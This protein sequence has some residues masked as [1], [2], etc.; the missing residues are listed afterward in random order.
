MTESS[1]DRLDRIE[2]TLERVSQQMDNQVVLNAEL[3]QK[4]A[5]LTDAVNVLMTSVTFL[6]GV[7]TNLTNTVAQHQEQIQALTLETRDI[8]SDMMEMQREMQA[9]TRAIR[10]DMREMQ[11]ENRRILDIIERRFDGSN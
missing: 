8:R 7:T 10:S 5:L 9:E 3:R 11:A 1:P 6:T 4:T 2:A